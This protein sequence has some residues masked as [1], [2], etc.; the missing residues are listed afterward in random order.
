MRVKSLRIPEGNENKI[1]DLLKEEGFVREEAEHSLW[2]YRK[3]NTHITMYKTGV[4]VVQGDEVERWTGKILGLIDLPFGKVA[5]C[6]EAGKGDIFG[7][8]VLCCAV[9]EPEN[10]LK[11]LE[12]CPKDSKRMKDEEIRKKALRLKRLVSYKCINI[13]PERFNQLYGELKNMN[14]LLDSAYLRLISTIKEEFSPR[15]IVVDQYS[16][17]NPF[18]HIKEVE[19]LEKGEREV[20]VSV[21]SILAREKF[22]RGLDELGKEYGLS[23]PKGASSE[24]KHLAKELKKKDPELL[25]KVAKEAFI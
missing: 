18:Q 3:G 17:R 21:A 16:S 4:L 19:F 25:R 2:K 8:L 7:S 20:A 14:R 24:A 15:R 9:I 1:E 23:L 6:D 11:V 10:F 22:L 12:V 13:R 5:G